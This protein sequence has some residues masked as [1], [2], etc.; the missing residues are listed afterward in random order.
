MKTVHFFLFFFFFLFVGCAH[1]DK[2]ETE[3]IINTEPLMQNYTPFPT[4]FLMGK[5][6]DNYFFTAI[7]KVT[8]KIYP[9][10]LGFDTIQ[11]QITETAAF[12]QRCPE[13]PTAINDL[14]PFRKQ[15]EIYLQHGKLQPE[16]GAFVDVNGI[17][18][19]T[20]NKGSCAI[21]SRPD[22]LFLVPYL[23]DGSTITVQG[24]KD[25]KQTDFIIPEGFMP[26]FLVRYQKGQMIPSP[27]RMDTVTIDLEKKRLILVY[28]S[29]F[30]TYPAIRIIDVR[31]VLPPGFTKQPE[32]PEEQ[33][34][35]EA[36][37]RFLR[38]CPIPAEPGEPCTNPNTEID[39]CII[40]CSGN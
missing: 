8:M 38:K 2:I 5:H 18:R 40:N 24:F 27:A 29:T 22:D 37:R 10:R 6:N 11:E 19:K 13:M 9:D 7:I 20:E 12:D 35:S 17:R 3:K 31:A 28:R 34:R 25:L 16:P 33:K 32:N 4:A 39:R 30:S 14:V 23:V 15:A 26:F 36:T 21:L 1:T